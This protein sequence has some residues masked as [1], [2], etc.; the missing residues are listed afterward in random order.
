VRSGDDPEVGQ[1]ITPT[2]AWH[3]QDLGAPIWSEPLVLGSRE[4]VATVGDKLFALEAASGAIV[5]ET[6]VGTPVPATALPCGDVTPTVG[7][8]GTPVI[9]PASGTLYAVADTWDGTNAHHELVAVSLAD[10]HVL[11]RTAV[12][13]PGADAKAILQ[14]TALNLDGGNVI[15]GF[16]GNDGDCSDYVGAVV[17]APESGAAASYWQVP[18]SAPSSSGG[19]IWATSGPS[20]G[21]E[22]D[23]YATTGNPVPPS[24]QAPG[25]Y[26]YSDSVVQLTSSLAP[27][28]S[29][30]PPNWLQEGEDDLDLSSA[31]AELLPGG[32]LFQAGKDGKGYLID[33]ATMSGKPGAAAVFAATVCG[34]H[35]SFGGDSFAGGVIYVPCTNGVQALAYNEAARSFTPLWQGPSDAFGPPIV[36]GGLVW[37]IASGG[38]SGGGTKLYALDPATGQARYTETLPSAVADHFASPSAAGG[39]VFLATGSSETA[40]T[41]ATLSSAAPGTGTGTAVPILAHAPSGASVARPALAL[42]H[43]HLHADR[44]GRVKLALRCVDASGRCRGTITVRAKFAES[45]RVHGRVLH[46]TRYVTLAGVHFNHGAGSFTATLQ[47]SRRSR[48]LLHRH[49]GRLALQLLLAVSG[50][51]TRKLTGTLSG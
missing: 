23:I 38:F 34:G 11:R 27:V 51:K 39:R 18:I 20:V 43:T 21:P 9:D 37:D 3:S 35:G 26:D 33:E 41:I 36:S 12:D 13:P 29:F 46:S 45:R 4:Y 7:I 25:P 48:A 31:G 22:G 15:F 14:R 32:L 17:S 30:E 10:G 8:V 6:S 44:K 16:G 49:H 40:Y 1:S 28:G 24:G 19:A 42:T 50:A 2:L 47:L 5:W